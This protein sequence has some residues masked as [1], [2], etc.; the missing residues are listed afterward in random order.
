M[1]DTPPPPGNYPPPP[2]PGSYPPPPPPGSYPPPPG[3]Y[4][5]PG[6]APVPG[7]YPGVPTKTN[8]LAIVSIVCSAIGLFCGVGSIAGIILGVVA[9]NQIKQ[10]GEAGDGLAL[11]G[12]IVGAVTLL[13]GVIWGIYYFSSMSSFT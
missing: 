3:G 1:T 10:T 12:I 7:G 11:A 9:K 2:P 8:T 4:P 5:P 6:G 13:I